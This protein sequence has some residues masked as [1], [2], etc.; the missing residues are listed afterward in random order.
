VEAVT[1]GKE[2]HGR[3]RFT[4]FDRYGIIKNSRRTEY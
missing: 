2:E 3:G 1:W 4:G